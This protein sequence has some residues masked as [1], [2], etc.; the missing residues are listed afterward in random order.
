[1]ARIRSSLREPKIEAM[2]KVHIIQILVL[3]RVLRV[4]L[5]HH[6]GILCLYLLAADDIAVVDVVDARFNLDLSRID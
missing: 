4:V 6:I 1:M 5:Q 2:R 3:L